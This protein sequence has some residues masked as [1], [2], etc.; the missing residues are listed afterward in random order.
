[1]TRL[2]NGRGPKTFDKFLEHVTSTPGED[3]RVIVP[4]L[5]RK[6]VAWCTYP[7]DVTAGLPLFGG[8]NLFGELLYPVVASYDV[9]TDRTRVGWS[10]IAPGEHR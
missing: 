5:Q 6:P 2:P 3:L 1:M 8:P 10:F 4:P 9:E 7:A